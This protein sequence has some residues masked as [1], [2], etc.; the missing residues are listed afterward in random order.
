[1]PVQATLIQGIDK[2][3]FT[4]TNPMVQTVQNDCQPTRTVEYNED[5]VKTIDVWK[6]TTQEIEALLATFI[7]SNPKK[8]NWKDGE[9]YVIRRDKGD[10]ATL[11]KSYYSVW[12]I[13]PEQGDVADPINEELGITPWRITTSTEQIDIIN[14]YIIKKNISAD[15]QKLIKRDRLAL[16][17]NSPYEQKVKYMYKTSLTGWQTL[18]KDPTGQED[19]PITLEIAKYVVETG[20][21]TM[22]LTTAVITHEDIVTGPSYV[23]GQVNKTSL[24]A[25]I[26]S[27]TGDLKFPADE[28]GKRLDVIPGCPFEFTQNYE[29]QFT[30]RDWDLTPRTDTGKYLRTRV[31][32]S[33]PKQFPPIMD[34]TPGS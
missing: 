25:E 17:E 21:M 9:S 3:S 13:D 11:T 4:H 2:A 7:S 19:S 20:R 14:Y 26:A 1:M 30:L 24:S 34:P 27:Q 15:D 18:D 29:Q 28:F 16:W 22:P 23:R 31:Y 32:I 8:Y 10:L 5:G 6:G 12:S 33:F